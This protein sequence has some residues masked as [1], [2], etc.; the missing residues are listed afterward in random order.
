MLKKP[1]TFKNFDGVVM[2]ENFYFNLT[3]TELTKME[4]GKSKLS[5][6][7][8]QSGGM[9]EYLQSVVESGD[10]QTIV[11]AFEMFISASYGVKSADGVHHSKSPELLNEF[12]ATAAYD[13][14]FM[15]LVTDAEKGAEFINAIMP[16]DLAGQAK[17]VLAGQTPKLSVVDEVA[18]ESSPLQKGRAKRPTRSKAELLAAYKA[19]NAPAPEPAPYYVKLSETQALAELSEDEFLQWLEAQPE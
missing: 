17:E 12:M 13:A 6:D 16:E 3:K 9:R 8:T 7:G 10:G 11:D 15:E 5:Q 1:I 18:P 4:L 19:K 14:L 2:T